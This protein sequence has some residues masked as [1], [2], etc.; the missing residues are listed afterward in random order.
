MLGLGLSVGGHEMENNTLAV[1]MPS[2]FIGVH[3]RFKV[4]QQ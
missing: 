3:R 4:L 2:A 1:E